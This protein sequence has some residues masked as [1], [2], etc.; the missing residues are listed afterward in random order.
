MKNTS[1]LVISLLLSFNSYA[2]V[3]CGT[4]RVKGVQIKKSGEILY[5][6]TD[7]VR[8]LASVPNSPSGSFTLEILL[9]AVEKKYL[10]QSAFPDGYDCKSSNNKIPA[11]WIY[12]QDPKS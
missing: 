7:G 2:S 12:M 1:I 11:E 9:K 6:S 4:E 10:V 5:T 3:K 8:R